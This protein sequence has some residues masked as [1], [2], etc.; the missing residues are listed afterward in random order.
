MLLVAL[1]YD[2]LQASWSIT[3]TD[4]GILGSAVF[5]GFLVGSVAMGAFGDR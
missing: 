1:L 4:I 5:A 3:K 2:P